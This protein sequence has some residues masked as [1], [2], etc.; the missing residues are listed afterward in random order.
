[1]VYLSLHLCFLI[2]V[3]FILPDTI[4]LRRDAV[5]DSFILFRNNAADIVI[6]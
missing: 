4:E 2:L 3:K 1:M 6:N 5:L